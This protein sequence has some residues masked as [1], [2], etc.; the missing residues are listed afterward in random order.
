[1]NLYQK[2]LS[3]IM[4][5]FFAIVLIAVIVLAVRSAINKSAAVDAA[6]ESASQTAETEASQPESVQ[7]TQATETSTVPDTAPETDADTPETTLAVP[8]TEVTVPETEETEP[9]TTQSAPGTQVTLPA[10]D[11]PYPDSRHAVPLIYMTDYYNIPY[12]TGSIANAGSSLTAAAMV[13]SYY[14]EPITPDQIV[15]WF[16]NYD[17]SVRQEMEGALSILDLY[18]TITEDW[19][20]VIQALCDDK[21]VIIHVDPRSD[22]TMANHHLVLTGITGDGLILLNDPYKPNYSKAALA[23]GYENGFPQEQVAKG[24]VRAW[25]IDDYIPIDTASSRYAD[26]NITESDITLLAKMVWLEARSEPFDGQVAVVEVI[27]NRLKSSAF[28]SFSVLNV[29][30]APEQ[31]PS[32]AYLDRAQPVKLQYKAVERAL[33]GPNVLPED[34]YFYGQFMANNNVWGKIGSHYFCGSY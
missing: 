5:A 11:S 25:I 26:L 6:M 2:I 22:F 16:W 7:E 4:A 23:D 18:Y 17:A 10:S 3:G 34:I 28:P 33:Y 8:E 31:F 29:I 12:A 13:S 30:K 27:L 24:F 21:I 19:E 32:A 1:M 20:D 14:S 9:E 15:P